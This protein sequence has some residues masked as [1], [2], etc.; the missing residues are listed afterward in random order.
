MVNIVVAAFIASASATNCC[1]DFEVVEISYAISASII[2]V[3]Q[4]GPSAEYL[5]PIHDLT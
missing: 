4:A 1:V 2:V 5:K 3:D